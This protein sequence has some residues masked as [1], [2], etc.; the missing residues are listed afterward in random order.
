MAPHGCLMKGTALNR[1]DQSHKSHNALVSCPTMHHFLKSLLSNAALCDICPVHCRIC[2]R[3][4]LAIIF[5][6]TMLTNT[7]LG[8]KIFLSKVNIWNVYCAR[9]TA[10][11]FDTRTYVLVKVSK[12]LRQKMSRPESSGQAEIGDRLIGK[13]MILSKDS[14]QN[15]YQN[16]AILGSSFNIQEDISS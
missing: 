15:S 4:L 8:V 11:I 7:S 5:T 3:C 14:Y 13:N 16:S 2:E 6:T 12:C 10:F 9:V 1:I